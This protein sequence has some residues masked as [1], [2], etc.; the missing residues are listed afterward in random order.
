M[1][2]PFGLKGDFKKKGRRHSGPNKRQNPRYSHAEIPSVKSIHTSSGAE[3]KV[4]N[5]S[6]GGALLETESR[7]YPGT[8]I[9]L[10]VVTIEGII[11]IAGRVLRSSSSPLDGSTKY[12]SAVAF[13][14]P[15]NILDDLSEKAVACPQPSF[16]DVS[17]DIK[18]QTGS[19][20][21]L[22]VPAGADAWK[23][24]GTILEVSA[25]E[26]RDSALQEMLQLNDW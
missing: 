9:L 10:R 7:L 18:P 17:S 13:A 5:I 4:I 6:R 3:M 22:S 16:P 24:S 8:K 23:E 21:P 20:H 26:A 15:L 1:E 2:I 25:C 11:Q 12:Q 14:N 19:D